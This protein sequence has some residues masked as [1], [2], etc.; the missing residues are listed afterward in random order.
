MHH[1]HFALGH[2][3]LDHNLNVGQRPAFLPR[4]RKIFRQRKIA[5]AAVAHRVAG[6]QMARAQ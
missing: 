5:L 1:D 4:R 2:H 3:V 6:M